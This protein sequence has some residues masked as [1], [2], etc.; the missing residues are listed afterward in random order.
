MKVVQLFFL[1]YFELGA[2]LKATVEHICLLKHKLDIMVCDS[3]K[4]CQIKTYQ[5]SQFV[6]TEAHVNTLHRNT[7]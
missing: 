7:T 3:S 4:N 6:F 2:A 1:G 5:S